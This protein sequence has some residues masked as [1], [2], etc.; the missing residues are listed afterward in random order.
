[1]KGFTRKSRNTRIASWNRKTSIKK[2]KRKNRELTKI[3]ALLGKN[4]ENNIII[5]FYNSEYYQKNN[6]FFLKDYHVIV[7]KN[8]SIIE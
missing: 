7:N 4:I 1:M 6:F 5:S 3:A 2:N 8:L